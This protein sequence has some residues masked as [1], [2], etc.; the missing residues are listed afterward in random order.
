MDNSF[1]ID[2]SFFNNALDNYTP[3]NL[4]TALGKIPRGIVRQVRWE[5]LRRP[6]ALGVLLRTPSRGALYFAFIYRQLRQNNR[7]QCATPKQQ[8]LL[9]A[10]CSLYSVT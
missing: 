7:Q 2:F 10:I 4:K 9:L 6:T 1:S 5:V 3:L 8:N